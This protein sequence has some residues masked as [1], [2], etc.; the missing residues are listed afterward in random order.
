MTTTVICAYHEGA[1][2]AYNDIIIE[3]PNIFLPVLGGSFYYKRRSDLFYDQLIKDDTG[4]NISNLVGFV[5][6]HTS[7]YWAYKNYRRIGNPDM[8]GL[9]HYRRFLDV[10]YDNLDPSLIYS[11]RGPS[12]HLNQ[13][14]E[15]IEDRVYNTYVYFCSKELLDFYLEEYRAEFPEYIQYLDTVLNDVRYHPKNMF[16][17]SR[18]N[19]MDF[20][21]YVCRA[22]RMLFRKDLEKEALTIFYPDEHPTRML[23]KKGRCRGYMMELFVSIW[24]ERQYQ[25]RKNVVGVPLLEFI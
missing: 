23:F 5:N 14:N 10:D 1:K 7:L 17:M 22:L 2:R 11:V 21:T 20:M 3:H 9:C 18:E 8:I 15:L 13:E 25:I 19:F 6:E 16:I 12:M 4:T 24:M